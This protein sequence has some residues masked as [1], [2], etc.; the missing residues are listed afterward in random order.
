MNFTNRVRA[1]LSA[2]ERGKLRADA[3]NI[4]A[5]AERKGCTLDQWDERQESA[6][7]AQHFELGC[8][9][10][11][12]SRRIGTEAT[13]TRIDCARRIFTEGITNPGYQFFTIF[14]FGE[15]QFDTLFEMGDA[16]HVIAGLRRFIATDSTGNLQKAFDY[17]GWPILEPDLLTN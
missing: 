10:F 15:R 17:M 7:A 4:R 16:E 2:A 6:A 11:Y 1:P 8:W 12:Y 3:A 13:E 14:D 5:T 9:L